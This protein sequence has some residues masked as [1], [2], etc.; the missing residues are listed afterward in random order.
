MANTVTATSTINQT[1]TRTDTRTKRTQIDQTETSISASF[2]AGTGAGQIDMGF[3]QSGTLPIGGSLLVDFTNLTQNSFGV[4]GSINLDGKLV[5]GIVILNT[6]ATG[7]FTVIATGVAGMTE[8]F[9]GHASGLSVPASSAFTYI[10]LSGITISD[11]ADS[12]LWIKDRGAGTS[13]DL[14]IVAVTG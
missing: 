4:T 13:Y 1:F 5:K 3:E 9:D 7:K 11:G 14:N 10:N 2:T 12:Q 6:S 8:I